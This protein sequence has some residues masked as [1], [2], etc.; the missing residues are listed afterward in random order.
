MKV[1]SKAGDDAVTASMIENQKNG[2]AEAVT[3]LRKSVNEELEELRRSRA[4]HTNNRFLNFEKSKK[5]PI[6]L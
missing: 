5:E 3:N 4:A 1:K 2:L 6:I